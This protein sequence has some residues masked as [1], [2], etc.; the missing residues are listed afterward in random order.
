MQ[1]V[2]KSLDAV[3]TELTSLTTRIV[4]AEGE[5]PTLKKDTKKVSVG[6]SN[7]QEKL[8]SYQRKFANLED[9]SKRCNIRGYSMPESAEQDAP[10]QF[11]ERM[12]LLWFP[13]VK[14]LKSEIECVHRINSRSSPK[15]GDRQ[16]AFIFCCL[17]FCGSPSCRR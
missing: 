8:Q 11:L 14:H 16:Q 12:I 4:M 17:C 6:I 15:E 3:Q 2:A 9:H 13:T 5:L 1:Q 10:V 7:T